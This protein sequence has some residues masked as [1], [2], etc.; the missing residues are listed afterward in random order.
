[1]FLISPIALGIA[2]VVEFGVYLLMR[3]R[4][5]VAPWWDLRRGALVALARSTMMQ[6]RRLPANPRN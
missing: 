6:L 2:I 4:A 5:L 3:R 1:M